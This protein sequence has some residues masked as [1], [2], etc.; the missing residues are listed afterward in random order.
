MQVELNKLPTSVEMSYYLD[1]LQ[2]RLLVVASTSAPLTR[3]SRAASLDKAV[4]NWHR[5]GFWFV[6]GNKPDIVSFDRPDGRSV[7]DRLFG[8]TRAFTKNVVSTFKGSQS[9]GE[10]ATEPVRRLGFP[11]ESIIANKCIQVSTTPVQMQLCW[12][13]DL[14]QWV[15]IPVPLRPDANNGSDSESSDSEASKRRKLQKKWNRLLNLFEQR[16]VAVTPFSNHD[17]KLTCSQIERAV[18][19]PERIWRYDAELDGFQEHVSRVCAILSA[20]VEALQDQ[21][22]M[23]AV[24]TPLAAGEVED[25]DV[26]EANCIHSGEWRPCKAGR[27]A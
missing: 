19:L 7:V 8:P 13:R 22:G 24:K 1:S 21:Q 26:H 18:P 10:G 2:Q 15:E 20:S 23:L 17:L 25:E 16:K 14:H 4:Q 9:A 12:R 6:V 11:C 5:D 3:V 27:R